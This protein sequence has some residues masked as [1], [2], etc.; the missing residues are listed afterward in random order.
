MAEESLN[1]FEVVFV[2]DPNGTD[3]FVALDGK[4]VVNGVTDG[5]TVSSKS[6]GS[7]LLLVVSK[8]VLFVDISIRSVALVCSLGG[9][10]QAGTID[11]TS[12][13]EYVVDEIVDISSGTTVG[14][15]TDCVV[16]AMRKLVVVSVETTV[17]TEAV[18]LVVGSEGNQAE[19]K[20]KPFTET[21]ILH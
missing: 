19:K 8:D 11:E 12:E 1:V 20:L 10:D 17:L 21:L 3:V 13:V 9:M 5:S 18:D 14:G 7:F 16:G 15:N 4:K 2:D 6:A